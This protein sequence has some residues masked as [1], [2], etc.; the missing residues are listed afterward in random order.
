M[1][2]EKF[3][4]SH[5]D[6]SDMLNI[7]RKV[8]V[9]ASWFILILFRVVF[10]SWIL[11]GQFSFLLLYRFFVAIVIFFIFLLNAATLY[12]NISKSYMPSVKFIGK[13][14]SWEQ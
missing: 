6:F 5:A 3:Y 2:K 10:S 4:V 1:V 12:R 11:L 8:G 13:D 9:S 7:F 14:D